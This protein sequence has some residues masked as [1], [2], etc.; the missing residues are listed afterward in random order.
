MKWSNSI[1]RK[2]LKWWR[3][4]STTEAVAIS[5]SSRI[6]LLLLT[7]TNT[8]T[9]AITIATIRQQT[10]NRDS[11]PRGPFS[12]ETNAC[13]SGIK[14]VEGHRG[15]GNCTGDCFSLDAVSLWRS[16]TTILAARGH[17]KHLL[18]SYP[19][20][21]KSPLPVSLWLFSLTFYRICSHL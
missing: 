15:H 13:Q 21:Y 9:I 10:G 20:W 11:L 16:F 6:Y 7:S 8:I 19:S 1:H 17:P 4:N 2:N 12:K 3:A 5:P 14:E 18:L